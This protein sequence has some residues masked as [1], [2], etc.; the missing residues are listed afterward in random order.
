[1]ADHNYRLWILLNMELWW[2]IYIDA[3]SIEELENMLVECLAA[4]VGGR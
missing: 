3:A 1:M 4:T 2:R